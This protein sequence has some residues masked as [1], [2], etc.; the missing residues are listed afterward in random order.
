MIGI[1]KITNKLNGKSYVGQSVNIQHR[2]YQHCHTDELY[3]DK[4]IQK[5][6]KQMFIFEVIE[7]CKV[8]NLDERETYWIHF[9]NT[10]VPN[11][12]NLKDSASTRGED[13]ANALLTQKEVEYLRE[14]YNNHQYESCIDIYKKD[15]KNSLI[16]YESF[17]EVFTG[18]RWGWVKPEVFTEENNKYY[19]E[20]QE[21]YK[22]TNN[23]NGSDNAS[24][25]LNEEDV[26]CI[27]KMYVY[28][29]RKEIFKAFPQY[30]ERAITS[31]ISG[32]NWKHL[33]IYKKREKQWY[34][35][36]EKIN[37]E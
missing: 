3:I 15:F 14:L 21:K 27:R 32:Q 9:C 30:S 18:L 20:T 16:K 19:K 11:G 6:G 2:W 1:Y 31:I 24:A 23:Q 5:Y 12:Y 28:H 37:V 10:L 26:M 7:L 8:D 33:P 4:A 29:E 17:R 13:N 34:L 22:R 25:I 36:G 35:E